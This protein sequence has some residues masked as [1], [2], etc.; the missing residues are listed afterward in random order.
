VDRRRGAHGHSRRCGAAAP[1]SVRFVDRFVTEGEAAAFFRRA[2]LAVLP[3]RE[4]E[5]SGV[6]L[7]RAGLRRPARALRRRRVSRDRG[8]GRGRAGGAGRRSGASRRPRRPARRPGAPRHRWRWARC[9]SPTS[10]SAGT[11]SRARTSSSTTR[12]WRDRGGRRLL[13]G[14]RPARLRAGRLSTAARAAGPRAPAGARSTPG[15]APA[16]PSVSL[17]IAAHRE[18]SIIAAKVAKCARAGLAGRPPGGHRRL[19]RLARRHPGPR[20]RP[21]GRRRARA[22][23][24]AARCARRTRPVDR[25]RGELLAFSTANAL[26]EPGALRALAAPFSDAGVGYACGRCAS[27]TTRGP[28]RRACTG[29]TR[30]PSRPRVAAGSRSP[31]ATA[32]S[33]RC[34]RRPTCAS[35]R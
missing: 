20:A 35:I 16:E 31:P 8:R 23:R 24:G 25:A 22:A 17:V 9:A 21:R 32:P 11:R 3:Y 14:R 26:W 33:T 28:T 6:P 19:R 30:W 34:A 5:Q 12:C 7:H 2:D 1:P 29:A 15:R 27:S 4:I 18:A 10:R 13:G